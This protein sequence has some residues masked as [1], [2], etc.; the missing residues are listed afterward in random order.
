MSNLAIEAKLTTHGLVLSKHT[1][2]HTTN[3]THKIKDNSQN[4]Q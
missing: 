4:S 1:N 2:P 3:Q